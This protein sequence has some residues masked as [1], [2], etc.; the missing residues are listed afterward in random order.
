MKRP[1]QLSLHIVGLAVLFSTDT[2][3]FDLLVLAAPMVPH[4]VYQVL[5]MGCSGVQMCSFDVANSAR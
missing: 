3:L 4:L 2:L 5:V 1:A